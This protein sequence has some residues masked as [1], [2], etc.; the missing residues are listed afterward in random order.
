MDTAYITEL[1]LDFSMS[2]SDITSFLSFISTNQNKDISDQLSYV[3]NDV[4][5]SFYSTYYS[6]IRVWMD[7]QGYLN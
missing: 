2:N 3:Q 1:G 6:Q 4:W 7:L 5:Q